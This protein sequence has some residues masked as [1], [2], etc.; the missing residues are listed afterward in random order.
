MLK[1][2]D[3]ARFDQAVGRALERRGSPDD[4]AQRMMGLMESLRDAA[5]FAQRLFVKL[6]G[7]VVPLDVARIEWIEAQGDYA[8]IHTAEGSLM[9]S[10]PMKKLESM[11][12]PNDFVRIHRSSLINLNRIRQMRRTESGGYEV[13][14]ASNTVLRVS[15]TRADRLRRWMV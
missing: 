8:R 10:Q 13:E 3:R 1:P 5:T 14:L 7:R 9:T 12:D 2:Y 6:R 4:V 15:R 11:L